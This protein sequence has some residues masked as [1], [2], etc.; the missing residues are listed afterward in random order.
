MKILQVNAVNGVL[1]TGRTVTE[2]AAGLEA[3]GIEN[4]TAYS[5][6]PKPEHGYRIG[7]SVEKTTHA[8]GSRLLGRQA[9]FSSRGT[10]GLLR[11]IDDES[12]DVVHLRN[13]HGNYIHLPMLLEYLGERDIPTVVNLDDCW[14]FTGKCCHYTIDGCHR[15]ETG[16]GS[17]PRLR[18]DN[19]SWFID[20]TARM[21]ADK[22]RLFEAIPRLGV[23]GVSDWISSEVERSF[24][25]CASII[26]RIY[27]WVDL[28]LFRP[29]PMREARERL[30]LPLD[31]V[32]SLG[33]AGGWSDA[34]GLSDFNELARMLTVPGSG[35][36]ST[37]AAAARRVSIVLVGGM[38]RRTA[39]SRDIVVVGVTHDVGELA[40]YY[41]AADAFLQLSPEETFGKVTAEALACGTPAVVY[42]S[43]ANPELV[44]SGCGY[45]VDC[46]DIPQVLSRVSRI[47]AEGKREYSERCRWFAKM[48][49]E[50]ESLID[51]HVALYEEL[52]A[53]G[54]GSTR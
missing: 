30:G 54:G 40:D 47:A 25:S 46:G 29:R 31:G 41:S 20:A 28:D 13:L 45:V 10:R 9:Y 51:E 52:R 7:T 37:A 35:G 33:V 5:M 8:L 50:K 11:Y 36:D 27:N 34:K 19:P 39:V 15:W 44:R 2:L 23:I 42:D 4:R 43:T 48:H 17:C 49:F 6:G 18:K 16:C 12:P 22:R 26:R 38:G 14:F 3:R 1:S 53:I 24:L 21:W 32:I